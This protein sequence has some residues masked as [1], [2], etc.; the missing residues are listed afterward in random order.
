MKDV[1]FMILSILLVIAFFFGGHYSSAFYKA[2]AFVILPLAYG[3]FRIGGRILA[4]QK[5]KE[6]IR[7]RLNEISNL[8]LGVLVLAGLLYICFIGG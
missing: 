2:T 8:I 7:K 3:I 6:A 1:V 5:E 4:R